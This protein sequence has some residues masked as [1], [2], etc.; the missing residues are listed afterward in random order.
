MLIVVEFVQ[1]MSVGALETGQ[2]VAGIEHTVWVPNP[3]N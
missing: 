3:V 2:L 1:A